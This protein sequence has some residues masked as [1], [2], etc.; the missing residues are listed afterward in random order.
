MRAFDTVDV[1]DL[2]CRRLYGLRIVKRY[3]I[4]C[5]QGVFTAERIED[6]RLVLHSFLHPFHGLILIGKGQLFNVRQGFQ[7]PAYSHNLIRLQIVL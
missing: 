6:P 5:G 7:L 1:P 2:G 4:G 3:F